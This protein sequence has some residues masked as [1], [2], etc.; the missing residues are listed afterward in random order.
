MIVRVNDDYREVTAALFDPSLKER[1]R[2]VI[3]LFA[4]KNSLSLFVKKAKHAG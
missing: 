1:P 4:R 2:N 3:R